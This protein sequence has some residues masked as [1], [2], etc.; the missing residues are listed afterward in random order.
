MPTTAPY[1][2]WKSPI[3]PD[4]LV[5]GVASL[6]DLAV[7]GDWVYWL[8]SRPWE[9]GRT[10]VMGLGPGMEPREFTPRDHNVRSRVHEY[11]GGAFAVCQG[12]VFYSNFADNQVYRRHRDGHTF[13]L[14]NTPDCR[15]ADFLVDS[16]ANRLIG[17]RE[18]HREQDEAI[19]DLV[20]IPLDAPEPAG[21]VLSLHRGRDFYSSPVLSPDGR[22]LAWLCWDHPD[23]PWD[24]AELWLADLGPDCLMQ[25]R[26]VAGGNG[27]SIFQPQW[28]PDGELVFASDRSGWWNLYRHSTPGNTPLCAREAEFG[29]PQWV[30]G[31]STYAFDGHGR[32]FAAATDNGSWGLW[33][34]DPAKSTCDSVP[35]PYCDLSG[36]RCDGTTLVMRAGSSREPAAV[37]AMDTETG[38]FKELRSNG[39]PALDEAYLSEPRPLWFDSKGGRRAHA[40]FYPPANQ[41]FQGPQGSLPPLLV[42]SHGGPTAA[43]SAVLS[44]PIQFWTSRGFAV[45]DV[46]YAGSTGFGREYRESLNGLWGIADV[47]DC[48]AAMQ[49]VVAQ[50]LVDGSKTAIRGSS[51]GG[52]TTLCALTFHKAFSAGASLYGISDLE[53]LAEDTHK[54]ESRYLDKLVGPY[55]AAKRIYKERSP[56]HHALGLSVPVIFFQ[57]EDDKVVPPSQAEAMVEAL[58]NNGVVARLVMYQGEGHGFRNADNIRNALRAELSFYA[59][60]FVFSAA[61]D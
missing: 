8:E 7:D 18:C 21:A 14:T 42:K 24:G 57:G 41:D 37:L 2:A 49:H 17:I 47:E 22:S 15:Y 19:N 52:Y 1:G 32:I 59:D 33:R 44:L 60:V 34:I 43:T 30:F 58:R 16:S 53:A 54:F 56:I 6:G 46:N 3:T 61:P 27:E 35:L 48:I 51:A 10:V 39:A 9:K 23:M 28:S 25:A 55:P 36:L 4:L 50:G 40:F 45:L 31:M 29:L 5:T 26:C 38:Q 13:A 20:S 12:E 11:G